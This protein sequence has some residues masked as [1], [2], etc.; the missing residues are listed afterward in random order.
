MSTKDP[1][2]LNILYTSCCVVLRFISSPSHTDSDFLISLFISSQIVDL[3]AAL[4][5]TKAEVETYGVAKARRRANKRK[6]KQ[7]P[8]SDSN[9]GLEERNERDRTYS[10]DEMAASSEA[11]RKKVALYEELKRKALDDDFEDTDN[12]YL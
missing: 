1:Y 12:T 2:V 10:Q 11:L 3:K 5:Q 9:P 7:D 8:F 4:F 6:A